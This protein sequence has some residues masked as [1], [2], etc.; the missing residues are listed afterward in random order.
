LYQF[1]KATRFAALPVH[2][3]IYDQDPELVEQWFFIMEQEGLAEKRRHEAEA[4]KARS[5]RRSR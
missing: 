5:N 3:G 4:R 1:A 2:G